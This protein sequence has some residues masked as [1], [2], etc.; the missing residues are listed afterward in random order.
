MQYL[1][2]HQDLLITLTKACVLLFRVRHCCAWCGPHV[3]ETRTRGVLCCRYDKTD[4]ALIT[5]SMLR[6]AIKWPAFAKCDS[7]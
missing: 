6:E 5:G 4:T 1:Q 3:G 2:E 7:F